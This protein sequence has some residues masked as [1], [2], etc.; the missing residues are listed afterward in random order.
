MRDKL[1]RGAPAWRLRRIRGC[2][3]R[4]AAPLKNATARPACRRPDRPTPPPSPG[5]PF[6]PLPLLPRR[7]QQHAPH[8][9]APTTHDLVNVPRTSFLASRGR[10]GR[11]RR[12]A[13]G[14]RPASAARRACRRLVILEVR[15][16][17]ELV[18]GP[19]DFELD[20]GG[21]VIAADHGGI[22]TS[23]GAAAGVARTPLD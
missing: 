16:V 20:H 21:V 1:I 18:L 13:G 6:A 4:R 23:A 5:T 10:S 8:S 11:P 17:L 12:H 22:A 14:R 3:C 7:S 9:S 2:C 15:R 19:A